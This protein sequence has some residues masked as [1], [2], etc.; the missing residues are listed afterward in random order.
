MISWWLA[1]FSNSKREIWR[2]RIVILLLLDLMAIRWLR[3]RSVIAETVIDSGQPYP[4]WLFP[5]LGAVLTISG[6]SLG[7]DTIIF[8]L[9]FLFLLPVNYFAIFLFLLLFWYAFSGKDLFQIKH[10]VVWETH[11][12]AN[13]NGFCPGWVPWE[14]C[15]V[16]C[17]QDIGPYQSL[18]NI[19]R[20]WYSS[21][22][23]IYFEDVF[24][25]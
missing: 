19:W 5:I 8:S 15:S 12:Q 9:K 18:D 21:C 22:S 10:D 6:M 11:L 20:I 3:I 2:K 25:W 23:G 1:G 4:H 24:S 16:K 14:L 13:S 17:Y 7:R